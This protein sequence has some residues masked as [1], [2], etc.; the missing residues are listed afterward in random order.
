MIITSNQNRLFGAISGD[1]IREYP[2]TIP[3]PYHWMEIEPLRPFN[4]DNEAQGGS[5]NANAYGRVISKCGNIRLR[6]SG[7]L[8]SLWAGPK[9]LWTGEDKGRVREF[10]MLRD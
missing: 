6:L 8:Y 4:R 1:M 3:R 7:E 9:L 2:A 5:D 10:L